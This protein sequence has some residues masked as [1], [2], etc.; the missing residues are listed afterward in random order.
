MNKQEFL[1]AL[2]KR[3]SGL[4]KD[5]I[6]ERLSF[7][8]E[9]IDDRTEDGRTEEEAVAE[10]GGADEIAAQIIADI[11]LTRLVK[12]RIKPKRRLKTWEIVLIVLGSPI[13]LSL[14]IAAAAVFFSMY[15]VL[16]SL[17][18][19]LWS[20]FVSLI[21]GAIA[22]VPACIVT[23]AHGNAASGLTVLSGGLILAGLCIFTGYGCKAATANIFVLTKKFA[24]SAKK[25]FIKK[26]EIQ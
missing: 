17:I 12:E 14:A 26:E 24:L 8:G 23:F 25:C 3:L 18:V 19:A 2:K 1:G 20:V 21:A 15:I 16:C 13:W 9:M 7:Y 4:P 6:E 22:A 11:P 5:E 10:I